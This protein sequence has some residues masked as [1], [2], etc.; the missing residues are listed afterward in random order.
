MDSGL[1]CY[2]G[3]YCSLLLCLLLRL[4][5]ITFSFFISF[6]PPSVCV[7][8]QELKRLILERWAALSKVPFFCASWPYLEQAFIFLADRSG[9]CVNPVMGVGLHW[10]TA[11]QLITQL[12]VIHEEVFFWWKPKEI[13]KGKEASFH[14]K[15][16]KTTCSIYLGIYWSISES[17]LSVWSIMH[18]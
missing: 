11:L 13:K 7:T 1:I 10:L 17:H 16:E 2:L 15:G 3:H 18:T 8:Q 9:H 6:Q 5:N 14:Y 4:S 12:H